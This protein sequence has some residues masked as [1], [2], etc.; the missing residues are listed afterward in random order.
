MAT[1]LE[2]LAQEALASGASGEELDKQID[3]ALA[4]PCVDGLR[5]GP[6]GPSFVAAFKCFVKSQEDEK[7]SEC[8]DSYQALQECMTKHPEAFAEFMS[9]KEEDTDADGGHGK[10]KTGNGKK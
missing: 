10:G 6:C 7:G 1:A 8:K 2:T 9:S 4:C 5:D 3:E